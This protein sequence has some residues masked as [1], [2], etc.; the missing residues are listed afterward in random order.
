MGH[1][2]S[3][4]P[5][6]LNLF[7]AVFEKASDIAVNLLRTDYTVLWANRVMAAGVERPLSE[8]VGRPCYKAFRRREAPCA[9]C[10]LKIV[11]TTRKPCVMERWLD[12]PNKERRYAEVRA[13]PVFD[14]HGLVTHIFEIITEI[15]HRK[16]DEERRRRYIESLEHTLR[17]LT[18]ADTGTTPDPSQDDARRTLTAREREVVR[19][20]AAGYSNKEMARILG[21][22]PDTVKTHVKNIFSKLGVTDRTRAAVWAVSAKLA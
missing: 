13:Y 18:P 12:L 4:F 22:S 15:T 8:I 20:I 3:L 6:S 16:K 7:A 10:L 14:R 2:D 9:E 21:I 1:S 5:L 17:A 11:S 19:L